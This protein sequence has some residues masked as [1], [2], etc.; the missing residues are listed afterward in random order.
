M[1]SMIDKELLD[2]QIM[3]LT[4]Y[5]CA[6]ERAIRMGDFVGLAEVAKTRWTGSI[7]LVKGLEEAHRLIVA[8]LGVCAEKHATLQKEEAKKMKENQ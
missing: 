7:Q 4:D 1:A 6:I 8:E 5:R 2:T 3:D